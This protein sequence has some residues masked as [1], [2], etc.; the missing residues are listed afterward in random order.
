MCSF[1]PLVYI[2]IRSKIVPCVWVCAECKWP[3]LERDSQGNRN[4]LQSL[5]KHGGMEQI[6]SVGTTNRYALFLGEED[7]PGDV[8]LS[9]SVKPE[10]DATTK[11]PKG[12]EN[13][14]QLTKASKAKENK[15]KL[16]KEQQSK[17]TA[18]ENAATKG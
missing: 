16:A 14:K 3:L 2:I 4:P 7:D 9:E 1:L 15:E 10:K 12:K 6:Y 17:K 18:I 13:N 8:I 11:G 5:K